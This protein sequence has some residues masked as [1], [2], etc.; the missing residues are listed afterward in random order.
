MRGHLQVSPAG[1]VAPRQGI[2]IR[3]RF[4]AISSNLESSPMKLG[5]KLLA[6]PIF[7]ALVAIGFG[8][9]SLMVSESDAQRTHIQVVNQLQDYKTLSQAQEQ[10]ARIHA[11]IYRNLG[12]IESLNDAKIKAIRSEAKAQ[13]ASV[14][15]S[16]GEDASLAH[17]DEES[18]QTVEQLLA[19]VDAYAKKAD[20]AIDL[21][22]VDSNTG[23]AAM[24]GADDAFKSLSTSMS[25]LSKHIDSVVSEQTAEASQ[26]AQKLSLFLGIAGLIAVMASIWLTWRMQLKVVQ[27]LEHASSVA[28]EVAKGNLGVH[29]DSKRRDELGDMLRA[30]GTMTRQLNGTILNVRTSAESL[31]VT[32][33]E[34][35]NG[36]HDLSNRTEQTA[37]NLQTAAN[38]MEQ[39]SGTV[40]QT[41]DASRLANK[42][43]DSAAQVAARGGAVVSQ[44]VSTMEDINASSR[45]IADI[46]S[47]IDGIA[48]Q[49]N[50]LAL[51]AA[52]EAARAGE[53]G[54]GFAVVASEVR[55]LA[56]R[57]AEAA[58]E[59]KGLIAA[60]VERVQA[61]SSL[62]TDAGQTM[63]EIVESV[64]KVA[65]IIGEITQSTSE[66]S[67]GI[68]LI[69][70][71]VVQLDQM[72]QQN[73][74][75]VEQ[76]AAAASNLR[77]HADGL[78]SLVG[79][80][81]LDA[82]ARTPQLAAL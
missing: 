12:I 5:I 61:G 33:S 15:N 32:S 8:K 55:S 37:T 39:L 19:Y 73:A 70:D 67:Q 18:R 46:I 21:S 36:N 48:F 25:G 35:A 54:K 44:V 29:L 24:Q 74:A 23:I 65:N 9:F 76:S 34:I 50:I 68:A 17:R 4:L 2:A 20:S 53:Q 82:G 78:A 77:E 47:V 16:I 57:S 80:F 69:S 62:V 51:N 28:G 81:R 52:V 45:K 3:R 26:K 59:I 75:L 22:T 41:A 63:T 43:A 38:S 1:A 27:E 64:R 56:G 79:A 7:T 58:K 11:G 31:Q 6:A 10:I 13:L 49:T 42:L 72:T 40:S 14:K 60:S 30:L 71:S 66:Q